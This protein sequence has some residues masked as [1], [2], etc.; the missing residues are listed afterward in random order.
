[1]LRNFIVLL[2]AQFV[3]DIMPNKG[4]K[5]ANITDDELDIEIT[6]RVEIMYE[7]TKSVTRTEPEYKCGNIYHML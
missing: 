1:M 5:K 3:S 6:L 7:D 4:K 2:Q